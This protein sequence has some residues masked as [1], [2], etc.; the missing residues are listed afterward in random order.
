MGQTAGCRRQYHAAVRQDEVT[1]LR[2]NFIT[3]PDLAPCCGADRAALQGDLGQPNQ[4]CS[5]CHPVG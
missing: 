3:G 4:A 2:P 5:L 1:D